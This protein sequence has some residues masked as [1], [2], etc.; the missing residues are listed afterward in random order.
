MLR[1][2]RAIRG[3]DA[4]ERRDEV[5]SDEIDA[6]KLQKPRA[7]FDEAMIRV[8]APEEAQRRDARRLRRAGPGRR[9]LR[10]GGGG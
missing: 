9:R 8:G 1:Q 10:R 6:A 5:L 4:R 3:I 7:D 2:Q